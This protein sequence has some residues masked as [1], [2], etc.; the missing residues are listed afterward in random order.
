[1][2]KAKRIFL[3]SNFKDEYPKSIRM[4]PRMWVKGLIRAGCDV[5]RF[6][7]RNIMLQCS[8]I[9]SKRIALGFARKKA[10][11]I[12]VEEI[13]CYHP[14]IVFLLG[15]KYINPETVDVIKEAA[16]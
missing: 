6:S 1:M 11:R 4:Q 7:Y 10:N 15:L 14:D 8:P 16:P 5:Y 2:L 13:K 12:L 3:I 9:P